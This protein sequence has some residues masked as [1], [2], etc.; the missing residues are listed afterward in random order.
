MPGMPGGAAEMSIEDLHVFS[1]AS[2]TAPLRHRGVALRAAD[3]PWASKRVVWAPDAVRRPSDGVYL[4]YFPA[5]DKANRWRIGVAVAAH[6]AGPFVARPRPIRGSYSI[7]PHVQL[8]D[9]GTSSS[10]NRG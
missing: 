10:S 3:V 8:L 9:T 4:L 5:L 1:A 2:S 6:P 7:D